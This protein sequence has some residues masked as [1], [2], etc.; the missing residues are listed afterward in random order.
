MKDI[1]KTN[2]V[3]DV[4][5]MFRQ[6]SGVNRRG[7]A[8]LRNT[9]LKWMSEWRN[10]DPVQESEKARPEHVERVIAKSDSKSRENILISALKNWTSA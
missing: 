6:Q 3:I 9:I 10:T 4:Q 1:I 8:P 5:R 7:L 2:S